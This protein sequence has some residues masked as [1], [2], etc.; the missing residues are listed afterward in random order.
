MGRVASPAWVL[1]S[2]LNPLWSECHAHTA[3]LLRTLQGPLF[4]QGLKLITLKEY[5]NIDNNL[6]N[7]QWDDYSVK[8]A[9]L[10]IILYY[11]A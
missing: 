2:L 10:I 8:F 4:W 5:N 6:L 9:L 1:K 7:M 11:E 3:R